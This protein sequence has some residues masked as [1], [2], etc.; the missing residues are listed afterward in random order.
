MSDLKVE[1]IEGHLSSKAQG[2]AK[3]LV[4]SIR[5]S[6]FNLIEVS[7]NFFHRKIQLKKNMSENKHIGG[8]IKGLFI[9]KIG[10]CD[11][12]IISTSIYLL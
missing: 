11:L 1:R 9:S 7:L 3:L 2:H 10:G 5:S 12:Y 8:R 4:W 6:N